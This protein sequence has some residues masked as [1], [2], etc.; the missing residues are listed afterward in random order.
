MN[1]DEKKIVLARLQTMPEN[2]KLSIGDLGSFDKWNLIENVENETPI[3][4]F[5]I[6]VYMKNIRDFKSKVKL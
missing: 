5:I 4:E 1:S 2:M 3:G 6:E